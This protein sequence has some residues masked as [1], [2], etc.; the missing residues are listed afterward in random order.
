M[1]DTPNRIEYR[2]NC[3]C[4]AFKFTF[5]TQPL[6][7]AFTCNC[8]I[9]F[10][11]GHMWAFSA[12]DEEFIVVKGD[13]SSL[14]TYHFGKGTLAHK[15]CPVCGTSVMSRSADGK[16]AVN[17]RALAEVDHGSMPLLT[18]DG[19][20]IEPLYQVPAPVEVGPV[21]EGST[22]YSGNCHCGA[23]GYTLVS[24]DKITTVTDCKCSIC[25]RNGALWTYPE[26][27]AVTF[28]GLESLAEYTFATKSTYHGFCMNCGVTI[29][30]RFTQP[31]A[32]DMAVNVRT[33][34]RFDLSAVEIRKWD[35]KSM[36][37][38]YEV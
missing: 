15:F 36:L 18:S 28:K 37:P 3:H 21:A 16:C 31:G 35:G 10:R 24:P 2:G 30:A 29:R 33:M 13:E 19:A 26:T 1:S 17:I 4:G 12:S 9:C 11:N 23:V 7:Q 8:S 25:S 14:K 6:E 27:T 5:N 34:D 38:S 22:V 20:A 32:T